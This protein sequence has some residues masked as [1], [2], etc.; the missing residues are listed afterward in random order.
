[1]VYIMGKGSILTWGPK[2]DIVGI[3][4]M[5]NFMDGGRFMSIIGKFIRG[6]FRTG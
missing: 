3:I 1:M 2:P 5:A 4:R 6:S